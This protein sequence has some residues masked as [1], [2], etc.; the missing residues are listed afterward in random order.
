LV[1]ALL[2]VLPAAA[3]DRTSAQSVT[4]PAVYIV[5]FLS[6][7]SQNAEPSKQRYLGRFATT[8][9]EL[10]LAESDSLDIRRVSILP[11]CGSQQAS[12]AALSTAPRV[13]GTTPYYVIRGS[14]ESRTSQTQG[15]PTQQA[16]DALG[17]MVLNYELAKVVN[18]TPQSLA[19]SSTPFRQ[20][21]ALETLSSMSDML[22]LRLRD[23]VT[24][25]IKVDVKRVEATGQSGDEL[26]IAAALSEAMLQRLG[27]GGNYEP[28][29]A[30]DNAPQSPGEYAV[31]TKLQLKRRVK[32]LFFLGT[33]ISGA[34]VE[35]SIQGHGDALWNKTV[36][37]DIPEKVPKTVDDQFAG[38]YELVAQVVVDGL[39]AARSAR[40]VNIDRD[41]T[42]V[43]D[44]ELRA[45]ADALLCK[46]SESGCR[47]R[48]EAA[49]PLLLELARRPGQGVEGTE[50]LAQTQNQLGDYLA[51]AQSFDKAFT[52]SAGQPPE[53]GIR[54]LNESGD[55]WYRA[56]N[57][58]KAAEKY[59]ASLDGSTRKRDALPH[60]LQVQPN[61]QLQLARSLRFSGERQEAFR[62]LL[63]YAATVSDPTPFNEELRELIASMRPDELTWA[64]AQISSNEN[65]ALDS[66]VRAALYAQM[67]TQAMRVTRDPGQADLQL[68]KAEAIPQE[69][70]SPSVRAMILRS[71]GEWNWWYNANWEEAERLLQQVLTLDA[72]P[73]SRHELA[74]LYY[75]WAAVPD[76]DQEKI[77]NRWRRAAEVAL[78]LVERRMPDATEE[79]LHYAD[80]IYRNSNH[81]LGAEKD[82]ESRDRFQSVLQSHPSDLSALTSLMG[83]CTDYLHDFA[84]ALEGAKALD[85][86]GV[87]NNASDLLDVAEI[88]VLTGHYDEALGKIDRVA[89]DS[90]A[91]PVYHVVAHFYR[92]WA[93]LGKGDA[94]SAQESA[95]FWTQDM[96]AFRSRGNPSQWVFGGAP[97]ALKNEPK[98]SE[99]YKR[100]LGE[101]IGAMG[102]FALPLPTFPQ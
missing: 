6:G 4:R 99:N 28:Q 23:A 50:L 62:S 67:A 12:Q 30:R 21:N 55:A 32:P 60:D 68:R 53:T 61:I 92:T 22:A 13:D 81:Q 80:N 83:V 37:W 56:Q 90:E 25:R 19:R 78:P 69:T 43:A 33:D 38:L 102:D 18:C 15:P 5:E 54:L 98:L 36:L 75:D 58:A 42:K 96:S 8:L 57:Y 59:R 97:A 7:A 101:M 64:E 16:N 35:L 65:H 17:E 2:A 91:E 34:T 45:K 47:P 46:G 39:N 77:N 48:P 26:K 95:N 10:K 41:L 3:Q 27:H 93:L 88:Y 66:N 40:A 24:E 11:L 73:T 79:I 72:T 44:P 31:Q 82:R 94:K 51:A 71:R 87:P 1:A 84:C 14:I 76:A 100:M 49:L 70:L 89:G 20:D 74:V 63:G 85:T 86:L 52:S 9:A 29:D